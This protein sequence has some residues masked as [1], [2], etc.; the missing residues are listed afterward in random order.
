MRALR[1][2][3]PSPALVVAVIALLVALGGSGYAAVALTLPANSVGTTQLKSNAV[4]S[5]KV[6]DH[7]LLKA[8]FASGQ[9]PAGPRGAPGAPGPPGSAGARGP[10]GP[11]GPA[12]TASTKWALVGKGGNVIASSTPAPLVLQGNPGQYYVNF[13][14]PVTGH[15]VLVS[16]VYRDAD[17]GTR[18]TV[19]ATI[20][21]FTSTSSPPDTSTCPSNNSTST[22]FVT[23]LD[24]G[25]NFS[26]SHPFYIVV[27]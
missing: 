13:G 14:T 7:S 23:T 27:D 19:Y 22:V 10:T 11:A 16:S 20:C 25:N 9:I 6:K 18:G 12:G 21:G 3:R 15:A 1:A 24:N 8:D 4:I 2:L 26:A 5:S 17:N